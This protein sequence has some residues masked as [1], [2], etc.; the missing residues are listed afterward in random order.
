MTKE[1]IWVPFLGNDLERE[2]DKDS[3]YYDK[4]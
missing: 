2:E 1:L 4:I 3:Y